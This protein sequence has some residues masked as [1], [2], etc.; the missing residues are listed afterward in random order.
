LNIRKGHF[1]AITNANTSSF[2]KFKIYLKPL[3]GNRRRAFNVGKSTLINQVLNRK[4]LV[5]VS[6]T[7]GKTQALN[8]FEISGKYY[9]VDLPGFGYARIPLE[10]KRSWGDLIESYLKVSEFKG[11]IHIIDCRR[12]VGWWTLMDLNYIKKI[13]TDRT[14]YTFYQN[15]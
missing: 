14:F 4:K 7:P 3:S 2:Y 6:K 13:K 11:L 9:F 1:Y 5:Q 15:R 8:Y 12:F 10:A